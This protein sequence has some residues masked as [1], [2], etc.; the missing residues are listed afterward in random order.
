MT[1][2][3]RANPPPLENPIMWSTGATISPDYWQG[4]S[5]TPDNTRRDQATLQEFLLTVIL[6]QLRMV[7]M[8]STERYY[9]ELRTA[10]LNRAW[11]TG[12]KH[13]R[14]WPECIT[15]GNK[16][17]T[18]AT[19]ASRDTNPTEA[20]PIKTSRQL[21]LWEPHPWKADKQAGNADLPH[22]MDEDASPPESTREEERKLQWIHRWLEESTLEELQA[23][24]QKEARW[25]PSII[26]S[27]THQKRYE[28]H[29][30]RWDYRR[31]STITIAT[32][33]QQQD[34]MDTAVQAVVG[35]LS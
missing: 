13:L 35:W 9:Q 14:T 18:K 4:N 26:R 12:P 25:S 5:A 24:Q 19:P 22:D 16:R 33:T 7:N 1:T 31:D 6:P 15:A 30:G 27:L 32:V 11:E 34:S 8:E 28:R 29:Q 10:V 2:V 3:P 20:R 17:K 23:Q 21:Y